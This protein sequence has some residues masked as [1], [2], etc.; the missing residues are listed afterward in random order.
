MHVLIKYVYL[1]EKWRKEK[2]NNV[3]LIKL[4]AH[5]NSVM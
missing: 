1:R 3:K 4:L 2:I 5:V